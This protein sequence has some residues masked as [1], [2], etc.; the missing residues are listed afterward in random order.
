[1][2][3]C[4]DKNHFGEESVYFSLL[5]K[6]K[7]SRRASAGS[8][9]KNLV[10]NLIRGHWGSQ[11]THLFLIVCSVCLFI[12]FMTTHHPHRVVPCPV[13][14]RGP[15][16]SIIHQE[17]ITHYIHRLIL[18]WQFLNWSF[19]FPNHWSLCQ[20]VIKV[21]SIVRLSPNQESSTAGTYWVTNS[22]GWWEEE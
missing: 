14:W 18:G 21:A 13:G 11:L 17:L 5:Y 19:L 7:S 22:G 1:M 12:S 15:P 10:R 8:K 9:D 6:S 20:V 3:K 16:T 4:H 2:I